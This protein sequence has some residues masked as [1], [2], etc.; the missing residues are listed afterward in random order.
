V[1]KKRFYCRWP[2]SKR[3]GTDAVTDGPFHVVFLNT[4]LTLTSPYYL[5]N[6]NQL[7][8]VSAK[9]GAGSRSVVAMAGTGKFVVGGNWKCNGN[10]KSIAKLVKDLNAGEITADVEVICAPPMVYLP[11]VQSTLDRKYQLAAQNCWVGAGGAFTGEIAA[12]MLVDANI[13]W[14]I[15]GHSERRALCGETDEFVGKK[16]KY[17]LDAGLSVMA[18]IGETL[19]EREAGQTLAVCTRQLQA[20]CNEITETDWAKVVIAYEPVWAIG[21]GKVASPEQAQDVHAG[22]RAFVS[23]AVSQRVASAVRIQYG[24][25]VNAGNCEALAKQEDIDGFLVG[26]ASL[27]GSDFVTICNAARFNN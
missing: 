25:S 12:E 7:S 13:P 27:V 18:C 21:T 9:A 2:S 4:T 6:K 15:L 1:P 16:T 14:V 23:K 11:K 5:S 22:I 20:I 10:S 17:A 8:P 24:G 26:G 3:A 19:D